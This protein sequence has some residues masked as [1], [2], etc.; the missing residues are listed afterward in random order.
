M[1]ASTAVMTPHARL[2]PIRNKRSLDFFV[3]E[4][5][6]IGRIGAAKGAGHWNL[7]R[8]SAVESN[9]PKLNVGLLRRADAGGSKDHAAA[10]WG[11]A[12]DAI[13]PRMVCQ[14]LRIPAGCWN[15]VDISIPGDGRSEGDL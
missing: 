5:A 1:R 11:P 3:S 2:V 7:F 10:I 13:I 14:S 6:P 4:T 8:E 12:A 9:G 15:H